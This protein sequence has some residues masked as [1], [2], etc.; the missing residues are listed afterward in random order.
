MGSVRVKCNHTY[1]FKNRLFTE[2]TE[3][4]ENL[5]S[6]T[7]RA[8]YRVWQSGGESPPQF[9]L[10]TPSPRKVPQNLRPTFHVRIRYL[11]SSA[12]AEGAS[13]K[14][15]EFFDL[16]TS[17]FACLSPSQSP[18]HL[19]ITN[20]CQKLQSY[21]PTHHSPPAFGKGQKALTYRFFIFY[22]FF[23][24]RPPVR[25]EPPGWTRTRRKK[26]SSPI[27]P[28]SSIPNRSR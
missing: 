25:F 4:D 11:Y 24:A 18:E 28:A 10:L 6:L 12:S 21:L 16:E 20:S 27:E 22:F 23:F 5:S 2:K 15:L 13:R 1:H 26:K 3:I 9:S 7:Y 14:I 8:L 17:E 19:H